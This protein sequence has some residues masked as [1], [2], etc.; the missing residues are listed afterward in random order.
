VVHHHILRVT[1]IRYYHVNIQ[2]KKTYTTEQK[3]MALELK[4]RRMMRTD[5]LPAIPEYFT[6]KHPREPLHP[7]FRGRPV[8][9]PLAA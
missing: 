3:L 7:L 1:G 8:A 6:P 9:F 4:D 2:G 5:L